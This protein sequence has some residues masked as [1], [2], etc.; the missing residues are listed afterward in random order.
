MNRVLIIA[1]P[2]VGD[3]VMSQALLKLLKQQDPSC[4][5]D[6]FSIAT[7]HD[8]LKHMP[9]VDNYLTCPFK[10][11]EL[12]LLERFKVAKA[13]KEKMYTHAYIIPSSFKSA[14]IPFLANIPIR[15]GRLGE[16]RYFVINNIRQAVTTKRT[17][18]K[19]L[20][21][22]GVSNDSDLPTPMPRPKLSLSQKHLE[23]TLNKLKIDTPRKP[24]LTICPGAAFGKAK[25]W[26]T[27]HFAQIAKKKK[28]DGWEV[29]ILGGPD[30]VVAAQEI[31]I[32]SNNICTDFTGKTDL[33]DAIALLSLSTVTVANDS[34]LM[35]I[36][37]SLDKAVVAIY[38]PTSP[39]FAPP[40]T[41]KTRS[42]SLNLACSPC[43]KPKCKL[44]HMKCLNDLHPT[45]VLQAIE[46]LSI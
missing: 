33:S 46:E 9:E 19:L 29:W 5:I 43:R 13:I 20:V 21:S 28:N 26:P 7:L 27:S 23:K 37:A 3:M 2:M 16:S 31:Q 30:E 4:S 8:L 41:N 22:L 11:G 40:L 1:P 6:I 32:L 34:G 15:I 18:V 39:E 36:A 24:I 17:A 25:R 12:Q 14:I 35:H 10:H 38:G 44:Q 45:L 42:L